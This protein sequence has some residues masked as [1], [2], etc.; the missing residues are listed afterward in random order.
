[1]LVTQKISSVKTE[2]LVKHYQ[3]GHPRLQVLIYDGAAC[4][5]YNST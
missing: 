1:M 5:L 3:T 2:P 4:H